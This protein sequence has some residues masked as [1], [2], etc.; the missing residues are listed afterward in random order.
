ML[1]LAVNRQKTA[2][3]SGGTVLLKP[4]S[5]I[6]LPKASCL[7]LFLFTAPFSNESSDNSMPL[8]PLSSIPTNPKTCE[9]MVVFV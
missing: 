3:I 6:G 9:A 1:H 7:P 4:L 2:D 5:A 8:R